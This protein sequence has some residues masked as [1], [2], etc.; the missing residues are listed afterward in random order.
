MPVLSRLLLRFRLC[1]LCLCLVRIFYD[2]YASSMT[3]LLFV[4]LSHLLFL[5]SLYLVCSVCACVFVCYAMPVLSHLLFRLR[6]R[7]LCL[8]L[9]R[10]FCGLFASA[11]PV[12]IPAS[13]AFCVNAIDFFFY[14]LRCKS[15]PRGF[16]SSKELIHLTSC[17][18]WI[19]FPHPLHPSSLYCQS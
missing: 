12:P 7:L 14:F 10:M 8:C 13:F 11:T 18:P 17:L 15:L 9:I 1:L 2:L 5:H 4:Y 19:I 3:R 6:L 16:T